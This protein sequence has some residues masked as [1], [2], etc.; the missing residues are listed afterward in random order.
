MKSFLAS[1][2][3]RSLGQA[4]VLQPRTAQR[5]ESH[6]MVSSSKKP[7]FNNKQASATPFS[8]ADLEMLGSDRASAFPGAFYENS[9]E[10]KSENNT[11]RSHQNASSRLE[12]QRDSEG[13]S[14]SFT[15]SLANKLELLEET[16]VLNKSFGRSIDGR[17]GNSQI[18]AAQNTQ[19]LRNLSSNFSNTNNLL[20]G[21]SQQ[22]GEDSI[23]SEHGG[24]NSL[25]QNNLGLQLDQKV[26]DNKFQTKDSQLRNQ[27][28]NNAKHHLNR[29]ILAPKSSDKYFDPS[30]NESRVGDSDGASDTK[31]SDTVNNLRVTEKSLAKTE[32][33]LDASQNQNRFTRQLQALREKLDENAESSRRENGSENLKPKNGNPANAASQFIPNLPSIQIEIG[34]VVIETVNESRPKP[35]SQNQAAQTKPRR[36]LQ[37]YLATRGGA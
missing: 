18:A 4:N 1:M 19:A 32:K 22:A 2:A 37:E 6:G 26:K 30:T 10:Y 27:N 35:Q 36:S 9:Q 5:F 21:E 3:Q 8:L 12:S 11:S 15:N 25:I 31:S 23:R 28:E 16:T 17:N 13:N 33:S 20:P 7:S 29:N 14:N 34:R 24:K